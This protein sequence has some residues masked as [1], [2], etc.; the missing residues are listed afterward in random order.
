MLLPLW[1]AQL[2]APVAQRHECSFVSLVNTN[3]PSDVASDIV[4]VYAELVEEHGDRAAVHIAKR[5]Q[6]LRGGF[7]D[8][9]FVGSAFAY[10]VTCSEFVELASDLWNILLCKESEDAEATKCSSQLTRYVN[11]TLAL[12]APRHEE[13]RLLTFRLDNYANWIAE[14]KAAAEIERVPI[15]LRILQRAD[16]TGTL[17]GRDAAEKLRAELERQ[18]SPHGTMWNVLVE[19]HAGGHYYFS[20]EQFNFE[21]TNVGDGTPLSISIFDR[22]CDT[23]EREAAVSQSQGEQ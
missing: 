4:A 19:R 16:A 17:H 3:L 15:V 14:D 21:A 6:Q 10:S 1:L 23:L 8:A 5:L 13:H 9:L 12:P 11:G 7:W 22:Q 18:L 2:G 20:E